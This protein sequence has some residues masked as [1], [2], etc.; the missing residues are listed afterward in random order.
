MR[1]VGKRDPQ[2]FVT[3][4]AERYRRMLRTMLRHAIERLSEARRK[5][6]LRG[7]V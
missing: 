4:L 5:R 6:H 2:R 7:E 3:F 1:K